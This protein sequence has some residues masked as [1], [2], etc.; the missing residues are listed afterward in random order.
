[1]ALDA[2]T[3][4]NKQA[5]LGILAY[6]IN[7][8]WELEEVLI[9]FE[10]LEGEHTGEEMALK[11]KAV[12]D[13]FGIA[14]RLGTITSDNA[15]NNDTLNMHLAQL[16]TLDGS[17]PTWHPHVNRIGCLAHT[18][19]LILGRFIGALGFA[20]DNDTVPQNFDKDTELPL[21][22]S[23]KAGFKKTIMK[24]LLA[25]LMHV[26]SRSQS[27]VR[28]LAVAIGSSPQRN[29]VFLGL[30]LG[31]TKV[32]RK[33]IRDVSTRW[34]ST[35]AMLERAYALRVFIIH[36]VTQFPK[37][38]RYQPLL[39]SPEEWSL[40]E[41]IMTVLKPLRQY[42]LWI[43]TTSTITI[44]KSLAVYNEIINNFDGVIESLQRKR[45]P[46]KV[47]VRTMHF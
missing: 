13:W 39:L 40:I 16:L 26:N 22:D 30:Q 9:G 6:Y 11:T 18:I 32:V 28:M 12:L 5:Y 8:A 3:A 41:Y 37:H 20:A 23:Q 42:T 25:S 46:W 29:G 45:K 43:S 34:N 21:L 38:H 19:Q 31:R 4:P 10:H 17:N 14:Q 47:E 15:S 27:Q 33:M 2:W 24:V 1:L 35:L 44:H 7:D 36:W